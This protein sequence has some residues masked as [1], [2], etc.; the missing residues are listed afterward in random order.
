[1][2]GWDVLAYLGAGVVTI[3]AVV[4][5]LECLD[6]QRRVVRGR[7]GRWRAARRLDRGRP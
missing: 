6:E 2:S 7:D 1:M 4:F 5:I 3:F